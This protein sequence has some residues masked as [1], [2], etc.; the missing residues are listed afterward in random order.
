MNRRQLT[1]YVPQGLPQPFEGEARL[2]NIYE[3]SPYR[4]ENTTLHHYKDQL[5]NAV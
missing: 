4:K 5:V 2:N 1:N 3:S